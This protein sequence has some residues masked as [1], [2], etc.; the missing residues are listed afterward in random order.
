[1]NW[2]EIQIWELLAGLGLFL[3]GMYMLEESLK[4]LAGRSFKLFLRKHTTNRVKAVAAGALIT[5]MLQS[6]S[7]VVLMV[8]SFAGAGIIGLANGIGIVLGANLGTTATGWL[9]SL[10]GF[11]LDIK[12]LIFPFLAIGGLGL[13][14]LKSERLATFSKLLMGFSF[15]FLGLS[16]MKDGFAVFIEHA[17]LDWLQGK[18][19]I[20]FFFVAF[21]LTALIQSSSA[22]MMI[23][24]TAL[25]AGLIALEQ[26]LYMVIGA[27]L[28]TT[29]TAI[30]G[31]LGARTMRKRVGWAQ[32]YF[33][34]IN[35]FFAFLLMPVHV[36]VIKTILALT[37]PLFS[38][39]AFHSLINFTSILLI[40][41]F[42][43]YFTK[44]LEKYVTKSEPEI[45]LF[46]QKVNPAES[47]SA[48]TALEKESLEFI[49]KAIHTNR[50]FF[51]LHNGPVTTGPNTA[52]SFLQL[53]ESRLVEFYNLLLQN[54]LQADEVSGINN[55]ILSIRYA[56]HSVKDVKDIRHNILDIKNSVDERYYI[57]Y[58]KLREDQR[59]FYESNLALLE[60]LDV[61][62][63][64]DLR[65]ILET[66]GRIFDME[67]DQIYT[68]FEGG[69]EPEI[70]VSSLL[71]M[72][73]EVNNS[74]R[75]LVRAISGF[76]S[77]RED[78]D[79]DNGEA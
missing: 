32:F 54:R 65:N 15:M 26:S 11:K 18:P 55:S 58:Q 28:G 39:V 70:S 47:S 40:L 7:M 20:I 3:F 57:F 36:Y 71:N 50:L 74:N 72:V 46:I 16:Y 8:M 23:F 31:T 22:A 30:I 63:Q 13:I 19:G 51:D 44:A 61:S 79:T 37:D 38:M 27:D 45:T 73:R 1:M 78:S 12:E 48:A 29:V 21:F 76:V 52:Y 53:Y 59:A 5:A 35:A 67:T 62:N 17:D 9:V 49:K 25:A 77:D 33:N 10:L 42:L 2:D 34:V 68:M 56:S 4:L 6:S 60:N 14:F 24:L 64:S 69:A 75:E 66:Q 43:G 41:P